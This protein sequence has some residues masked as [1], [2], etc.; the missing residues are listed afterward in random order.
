MANK[1]CFLLVITFYL[2][3]FNTT[4]QTFV[5]DDNFEQALIDLGYDSGTLDDFVPTSNINGIKN[6][7]IAGKNIKDLTGIE[8]FT[9]LIT[10][11]CSDNQLTNLNITKNTFLTELYFFENLITFIDVSFLTDLKILWCYNN[12][13]PELN[14][15]KNLNLI[16][17][18][19]GNN[20]L[21]VLDVSNN[22]AL[23]VLTLE[24][25]EVS[26][27]DITK[28][29]ILNRLQCGKNLLTFLDI[30]KN[31]NL[32]YLSC[33]ENKITFLDTSNNLNLSTLI[34]FFNLLSELDVSKNPS[35]TLLDCSNN[36]LCRLNLKNGNNRFADVNFM[37][38]YFLVCVVVDNPFDVPSNWLTSDFSN[39]VS[40]EESCNNFIDVEV[41]NDIVTNTSYTLPSLTNGNY[42][43]QSGGNGNMLNFGDIISTSQ[44]I[45]I[46]NETTCDSKESSF[47]VLILSGVDYYIPKYFT[48]NNDGSHDFWRVI[49]NTNSINKITIYNKYGKLLKFLLPN[50][51]GWDGTFNGELLGSDD[52]WYVITLNTNDVI[53]GHFSLKR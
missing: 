10:L 2:I 38:N 18:V 51:E 11:D 48:P 16:S 34:C 5:P 24:N 32:S 30:S 42:F 29:S 15:T 40:S 35:L 6:L 19:C 7:D 41:I 46:Y 49:D 43:T 33:E 8:D 36:I 22:L 13:L 47:N 1:T 28:N 12:L 45:Y 14:V 25:N 52:Y 50:S 21:K 31:L 23:V 4:S 9:A 3:S 44:T 39:Y 27:I 37:L 53:K 26:T 17:L 20:L